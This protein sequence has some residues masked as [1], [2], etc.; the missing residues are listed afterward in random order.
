MSPHDETADPLQPHSHEPNPAPPTDDPNFKL[1]LG[2]GRS[3]TITVQDLQ[4]LPVTS[5]SNCFIVSTGHGTSG[6]FTFTGTTLLDFVTH[7]YQ[8]SW[9]ELE[10][11]SAD[12]FGNRVFVQELHQP[13]PAGPI[14]LAYEMNGEALTREQGLVRMIVP[15]EKDDALRQVK[16][17]GRVKMVGEKRP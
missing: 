5:V 11:V 12:G 10:V 14:L 4:Q 13:D 9:S 17:V 7:F 8:E 6:P 15:S 3:Q 1:I 2:N 16:W